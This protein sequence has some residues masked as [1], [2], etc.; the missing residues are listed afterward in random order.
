MSSIPRGANIISSHHLFQVKTGGEED[1]LRL[2]CR[3]VPHGDRDRDKESVRKA[4][5]IAQFPVIRLVLS[6]AAVLNMV[7]ATIEIKGAYLQG[8][9]FSR[10]IY[11]RPPK[12]WAVHG[13]LWRL[14][15]PAYGIVESGRLWQLTIESWMSGQG[16]VPIP[17][18]PQ[19]FMKFGDGGIVPLSI[20]KVVDDFLV[21]G[22]PREVNGF[23]TAPAKRF[24]VG[25]FVVDRPLI[26]NRLHI[27][28]GNDGTVHIDMKEYMEKIEFPALSL[29]R[30]KQ[31]HERGTPEELTAYLGLAGSLN[32]LG[33]GVLPQTSFA[34]SS[35]QRAVGNLRVSDLISSSKVLKKLWGLTPKQKY[36]AP[37]MLD[38]DPSY[39]C[40]SDASHGST[41]YGQTG[42]LSR[43]YLPAWGAGVY[44]VLD[45]HSCKQSRVAFSSIGAEILAAATSTDRGSLMAESLKRVYG[46]DVPLPF[47]LTV[48]SHGLYSTVKTLHEGTDYCLR[49]TA[50][51]IRD[52]CE[53]GEIATM[54]WIA[55]KLKLSDALKKRILEMFR[56]LNKV[57]QD[58]V[59]DPCMFDKANRI[60][61]N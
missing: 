1:K 27:S 11:F 19:L 44:R 30:K 50:A 4:S 24:E 29:E 21:V 5:A 42:I 3:M 32:F 56:K 23:H 54:Q 15:K 16:I 31:F 10:D 37:P 61:F 12:C 55:G 40:F 6:I 53:N 2:K 57:M 14:L 9:Y 38:K 17:G 51:R 39:L 52:S 47:I 45:W 59:F 49:P 46:S 41:S 60:Q 18:M 58:E 13:V 7:I 33:H 43:I 28:Q 34:A 8:G 25:R 48:D 36:C 22:S 26:F 35:L 20:C